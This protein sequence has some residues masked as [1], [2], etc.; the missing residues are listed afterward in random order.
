MLL[1]RGPRQG[2]SRRP[3]RLHA[4]LGQLRR[5]HE[6]L[7][8]LRCLHQRPRRDGEGRAQTRPNCTGLRIPLLHVAPEVR[9]PVTGLRRRLLAPGGYG[10]Q[11][12]LLLVLQARWQGSKGVQPRVSLAKLHRNTG[13]Q[14][15]YQTPEQIQTMMPPQTCVYSGLHTTDQARQNSYR[16]DLETL[17]KNRKLMQKMRLSALRHRTL[18]E[19]VKRW[20]AW[21]QTK[22]RSSALDGEPEGPRSAATPCRR[23]PFLRERAALKA[24]LSHGTSR[25]ARSLL[26]APKEG[27]PRQDS[28]GHHF[29]TRYRHRRVL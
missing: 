15:G 2:S 22:S 11:S 12:E 5:G 9:H 10:H 14:R 21:R 27:C 17:R 16:W 29:S 24:L 13:G 1:S 25:L 6:G 8:Y 28:L 18:G 3:L 19:R 7:P 23:P 4:P 26:L 20:T